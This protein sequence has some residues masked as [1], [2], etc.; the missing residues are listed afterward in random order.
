[1]IEMD[2]GFSKDKQLVVHHD[3]SLKRTC[4]IDKTIDEF[5]Y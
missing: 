4:G 1:M 2:V 5:N 3:V